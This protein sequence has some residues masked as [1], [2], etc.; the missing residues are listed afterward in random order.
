MWICMCMEAEG[1]GDRRRECVCVGM[2]R[3][4]HTIP[5]N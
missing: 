2:E 1:T 4:K 5:I 3:R